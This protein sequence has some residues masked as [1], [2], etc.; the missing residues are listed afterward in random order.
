VPFY[1]QQK[2]T[3]SASPVRLSGGA[4][5]RLIE[6]EA[7]LRS[8]DLS[9]AMAKINQLRTAAGVPTRTAANINEGWTFLKREKGIVLWLESRRMADL[10]RWKATN[11][12]GD[13]DPLELP[14]GS[15]QTGSHLVRQD[16]C[17][18]IPLSE[19]QTNPNIG[20][21]S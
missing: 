20:T 13:L 3:S 12:P 8:N 21:T 6:A 5:M 16:L 14:S 2:Y 18:P 11:A 9:G 7:L 15:V 4:E 17:I 1:P 19:R 10:R